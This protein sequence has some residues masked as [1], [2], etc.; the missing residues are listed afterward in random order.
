VQQLQFKF[1]FPLTE[2]N[3]LDLDY[4]PCLDYVEEQRKKQLYS[5][6]NFNT[7]GP[8]GAVLTTSN[9]TGTVTWANT[10]IT[11]TMELNA[12]NGV[13]S[14]YWQVGESLRMHNETTPSRLHQKMTNIF[15]GWK[16]KDK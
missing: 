8:N 10:R 15:F 4:K 6:Y 9:G 12:S 14:G 13:S 1:F 3:E 7:W 16:W 2:Q 11:N 5:G